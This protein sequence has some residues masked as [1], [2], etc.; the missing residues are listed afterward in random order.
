MKGFGPEGSDN[1]ALYMHRQLECT[2]NYR[3]R[4]C[5]IFSNLPQ[6]DLASKSLAS[7]SL[8]IQI[9]ELYFLFALTET[10]PFS[11]LIHGQRVHIL[12]RMD[13]LSRV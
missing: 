5:H 2:C 7:F 6:A 1:G 12:Q 3:P 4:I 8:H 10:S 11:C 9:V 13:I